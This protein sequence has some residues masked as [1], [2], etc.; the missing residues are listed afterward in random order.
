MTL[1]EVPVAGNLLKAA[2]IGGPSGGCIPRSHLSVSL[3]YESLN[4]LG[5]IMGSG[6]L[7]VMDESSC[8][9]DV[10]K[11]FLIL[12]LRNHAGNVLHAEWVQRECMKYSI[13]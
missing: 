7:V 2:Q 6:G 8:M 3:D 11:F 10:A 5:A 1:V 13:E 12:F 4:E 9:V